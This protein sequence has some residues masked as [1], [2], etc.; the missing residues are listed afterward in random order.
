MW[1]HPATATDGAE[2][3]EASDTCGD[4]MERT[5]LNWLG[6]GKDVWIT[7]HS[8]GGAVATAAA[9]HLVMGAM[10]GGDCPRRR[11]LRRL[12]VVTFN[13]PMAVREEAGRR[14]DDAREELGVTH[15]R[16]HN[17]TDFVRHS[18]PFVSLC[19]VGDEEEY[20]R[21]SDLSYL[22]GVA[23]MFAGVG[24]SLVAGRLLRSPSSPPN[25]R[26]CQDKKDDQDD[27]DAS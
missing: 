13:A 3:R 27:Q 21:K 14:Y 17:A 18:P 2:P 19:H 9:F 20:G 4:S 5:T 1:G 8:K 16:M 10:R 26:T 6:A 11:Q 12:S 24:L 22:W 23:L 15:R 25:Q 7:G